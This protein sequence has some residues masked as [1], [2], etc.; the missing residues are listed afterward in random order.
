VACAES[1]HDDD[2]DDDDDE[3]SPIRVRDWHGQ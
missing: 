2:D 3:A 1:E